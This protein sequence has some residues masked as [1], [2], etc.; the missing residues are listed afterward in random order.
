MGR[1][2]YNRRATP[3]WMTTNHSTPHELLKGFSFRLFEELRRHLNDQRP[4]ILDEMTLPPIST[5]LHELSSYQFRNARNQ[6]PVKFVLTH[7]RTELARTLAD[8]GWDYDGDLA[9]YDLASARTVYDGVD[10]YQAG[11]DRR[12]EGVLGIKGF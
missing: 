5:A 6:S 7:G 9:S 11:R 8:L 4:E 12:V 10:K 1:H 2:V 3:A